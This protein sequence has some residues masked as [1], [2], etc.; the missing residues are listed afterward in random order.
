MQY[1]VLLRYLEMSV[2]EREA[3]NDMFA[4]VPLNVKNYISKIENTKV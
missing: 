3:V 4:D 2:E 1:Y